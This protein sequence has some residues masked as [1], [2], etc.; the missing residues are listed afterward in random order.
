MEDNIL[1]EFVKARED[2]SYFM[3]NYIKVAHPVRGLVPFKLYPF[4]QRIVKDLDG[5]RFNILRKF[6]Q[7]GCTT[8]AGAYSLHFTNFNKHK[9]VVILSKGDTESTEVLDRVK[10]MHD[11]L[12]K[13]LKQP[14]VESNKHTLKFKNGS[15]IKSRPSGK[16]SG[17]SLAGSLLI[18]D[19]AAFIENIESIWAAVYPIIS[20]GGRAFILS[21]VNGMGNWYHRIYKEAV[22]K[23]NSFNPIDIEW[24]DHPEYKIQEGFDD[25]YKELESVGVDVETWEKTTKNNMPFKQWLQEYEC[26][27]LGTG[28]TY[29]EGSILK[30]LVEE[31]NPDYDIKYN[32]RMRVFKQPDPTRQYVIG[33]DTSLGRERDYSAFQILDCYNGEQVAEF[34]SNRTP[35]NEFAEIIDTEASLYGTALVMPER[36]TIGENLIDWLFNIY[37]Y[38]NLWMEEGTDRIGYLTTAKNKEFMLAKMEEFIRKQVIKVNSKRTVNELLTF[39]IDDNNKI[40]AD[41]GKHDDLIMSLALATFALHTLSE[42]DIIEYSQ[43]PHK[44]DIPLAPDLWRGK[45]STTGGDIT[46]EDLKW[47]LT[48]TKE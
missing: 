6:R 24:R 17:R 29:L 30:R 13:W 41:V 36:N 48:K 23:E 3:S 35:I 1:K 25:L 11:E 39:I 32:N 7:A 47:L 14:I 43:I 44:Q 27:F 16:Q 15:I 22:N 45:I 26:E 37:E 46:E 5:H 20:T 10:I 34:Y 28:D 4:Q 18:I 38:E 40:K 8:I 33:V 12:P 2:P 9:T 21:T 31:V 19:E 42:N